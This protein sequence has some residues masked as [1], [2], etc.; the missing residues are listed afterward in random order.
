MLAWGTS[1]CILCNLADILQHNPRLDLNAKVLKLKFIRLKKYSFMN[2]SCNNFTSGQ[3]SI[4]EKQLVSSH[5]ADQNQAMLYNIHVPPDNISVA[6]PSVFPREYYLRADT[7]TGYPKFPK[8]EKGEISWLLS[9]LSIG[10]N[11]RKLLQNIV[12]VIP[13]FHN[14]SDDEK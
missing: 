3:P 4:W 2:I 13:L 8:R 7:H 1:D 6:G 5:S 9:T 10:K 11:F 14:T 12:I